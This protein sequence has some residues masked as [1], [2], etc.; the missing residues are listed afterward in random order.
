MDENMSITL[1]MHRPCGHHVLMNNRR[2]A[3]ISNSPGSHDCTTYNTRAASKGIK[4]ARNEKSRHGARRVSY[5]K[6][7]HV[8]EG[9]P[10]GIARKQLRL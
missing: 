5:S 1:T 2:H 10:W 6:M 8:Q 3:V 7:K 9:R 4:E